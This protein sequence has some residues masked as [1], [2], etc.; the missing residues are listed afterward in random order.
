VVYRF[1]VKPG[2]VLG[3]LL[4]AI[5]LCVFARP[6]QAWAVQLPPVQVAASPLSLPL[7]LA[8]PVLG[9]LLPLPTPSVAVNLP[10]VLP[11]GVATVESRP[12]LGSEFT[13]S[14]PLVAAPEPEAPVRATGRGL[15]APPSGADRGA[16]STSKKRR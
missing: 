12:A 8:V 14:L 11:S 1:L 13:L 15:Q 4:V 5:G 9:S 10:G 3:L 2:W 7:P 16:I 6:P